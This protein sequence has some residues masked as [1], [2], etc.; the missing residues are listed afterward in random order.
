MTDRRDT[1]NPVYPEIT[2]AQWEVLTAW[3]D[4]RCTNMMESA[5]FISDLSPEAKLFLKN[6][7]KDKIEQLNANMDF[8]ASS[9]AIWKFIWIGGGAAFAVFMGI[10][11]LWQWMSEHVKIK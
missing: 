10:T 7:D 8:F 5:D 1:R 2:R 6:A 9:K 3:T 11:Q 4:Q